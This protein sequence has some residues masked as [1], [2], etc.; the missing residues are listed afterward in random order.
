M[1]VIGTSIYYEAW[2][3]G[4]E[5]IVFAHGCLLSCRLFDGMGAVLKRRFR[6]VTFDFRGQ[7]QNAIP[8][9]GYDMDSLTED[10]ATL[11][12]LLGCA[13]CHFLGFSMDGFLGIRLAVK[14]PGLLHRAGVR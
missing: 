10:T 4:P 6:Y 7:G 12:R 14:H 11:I 1:T 8:P 13:P 2:G 5:T 3:E 9:S